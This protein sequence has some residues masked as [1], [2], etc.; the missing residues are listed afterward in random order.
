MFVTDILNYV[1]ENNARCVADCKSNIISKHQTTTVRSHQ[2]DTSE[3]CELLQQSAVEYLTLFR[4]FEARELRSVAAIVATDFEALYAYKCG[5][6]QRCLRLSM[7]NVQTLIVQASYELPMLL[8]IWPDL[9]QLMDEDVVSL[10]GIMLL[11]NPWC[12]DKPRYVLISQLS[13]SLY[14]VTQCQLKLYHS[15]TALTLT[16]DYIEIARL[17]ANTA[18]TLQQLLLKL[19]ERKALL[20]TRYDTMVELNVDSKAGSGCKNFLGK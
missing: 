14:L 17:N 12:R 8:C 15:V 11:V 20:Y 1:L 2:L 10:T 13:L 18:R 4:H 3:L 19:T 9:I 7:Y 16:L 6:Y 5:D